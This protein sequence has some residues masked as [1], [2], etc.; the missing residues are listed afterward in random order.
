RARIAARVGEEVRLHVERVVELAVLA[1]RAR[2]RIRRE[3][4]AGAVGG[5]LVGVARPDRVLAAVVA[6]CVLVSA[7]VAAA[8]RI[9]TRVGG[10]RRAGDAAGTGREE[11]QRQK[12]RSDGDVAHAS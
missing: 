11:T 10:A 7:A 6:R 9:D 8:A 5:E 3:A 12:A 1:L 4:S 2:R